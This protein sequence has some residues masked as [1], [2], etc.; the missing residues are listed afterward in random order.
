MKTKKIIVI[1]TLFV[2][3][4]TALRL[5]WLEVFTQQQQLYAERG[6]LDVRDFQFQDNTLTLDGEWLFYPSQWL[7]DEKQQ[8][9]QPTYIQVPGGW[10]KVVQEK[11]P[12][13]Y[14]YG[15]YRLHILVNPEETTTYSIR[16]PS[17]R[18]ASEVYVNGRLLAK[19]GEVGKNRAETVAE[20]VPF[21]ASFEVQG[22]SKIEI[23]IQVANFQDPRMGGIVRSIKFG[24]EDVIYRETLLSITMQLVVAVVLLIHAGYAIILYFV[25][26]KDKRLLYFSL[27][28]VSTM[29]YYLLSNDDKLL[30]FWFSINYEWSFILVHL[31]AIGIGY[32]LLQCIEHWLPPHFKLY[33]KAFAILCAVASLLTILLPTHYLVTIQIVYIL[34]FGVSIM[35]TIV[36]VLGNSIKDI[37]S[38]IFVLLAIIAFVNSMI[39]AGLL[40]IIGSKVIFYPFDLIITIACLA[41]VWFQGFAKVHADTKAFALQLQKADKQKDEFLASTSHELRNPLHSIINI[42]RAVLDREVHALSD[43]SVNDLE[44]V[45]SVGKRMSLLLDDLL[46]VRSLQENTQK[47][48]LGNVSIHTVVSGVLEML[49]YTVEGKPV[50]FIHRIPADFQ[51]VWADENRVTQ[52]VLNLVHNAVKFTNEGYIS[53]SGYTKD[54]LAKIIVEDTGIGMDQETTQRIFRPYE[55][56]AAGKHIVEGGFGLGLSVSKR[57][58]E[59]QGGTLDV[60]SV[61][62]RGSTFT[63]TL[64]LSKDVQGE[65]VTQSNDSH[66]EEMQMKPSTEATSVVDWSRSRILVVDDEPIN[67]RVVETILT[68]DKYDIVTV[69]SGIKALECIQSQKWDVVISDVMMPK[70]SGYELVRIIRKQFSLTELPVLLL[71]ARS[72]PHQ[73]EKGFLVGAN[74]YVVKPVDALEL[75]SRV[76]ALARVKRSVQERHRMEAAW[77]Q[78]QIEPHFLFN[79]LNAILTLSEAES[80]RTSKLV[81]AL[82]DFLR[83]SYNFQ[84]VEALVPLENEL[85]LIQAYLYIQQERF[86]NRIQVV[87]EIEAEKDVLIPPL[88][89]QP[90]VEN[91]LKHGIL[92]RTEGGTICIRILDNGEH[93]EITV[94]D[95]GVGMDERQVAQLLQ[96]TA[97]SSKSIG[98]LNTHLRLQQHYGQGLQILSSPN[99]GTTI[100]FIV[101]AKKAV[102]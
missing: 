9:G 6:Q 67:L 90:L 72:Q 53:I 44:T 20:N 63:F 99:Q 5:V 26:S 87:W 15:S 40:M 73:I 46:D 89:M 55:Q 49:R 38:N 35:I 14:G 66:Q 42:S 58:I 64:P 59:L 95:D 22:Q 83:E 43:T 56:G 41:I 80:A 68:N 65:R 36:I 7:M 19:S 34:I 91:A 33:K 4:L 61:L 47:L 31:T 52:I 3:S 23:V 71:T 45:L 29:F 37:R 54:G 10:D 88:I 13:P 12:N 17:I 69:T 62:G 18:S 8:P 48:Q 84:N 96:R 32:P 79:T 93:L 100:S 16:V 60:Q 78:A 94:A 21:T 82:S 76:E 85:R 30:T 101:L 81:E 57:L 74:D 24:H 75:R 39:W 1:I 97:H 70:M 2:I 25:G 77:L 50:Q 102:Y 51:Q 11:E 98:L 86:G 28:M 92:K 27:L